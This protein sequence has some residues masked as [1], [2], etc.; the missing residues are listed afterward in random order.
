MAEAVGLTIGVVSLGLQLAES[1]Q[2]V[3]RFYNAVKDAPGRLAD[4]VDE[5][6]S[7]SDILAN[8]EKDHG[9]YNTDFGS[10]M[11]HCI[12]MCRKAV[13]RFSKCAD[14]LESR[15]KRQRHR[16][17]IRFVMKAQ[18]V[19]SEIARLENSKMNLALAYMCYREAM[20]ET[21]EARMQSH[22]V[23]IESQLH[24]MVDKNARPLQKPS[25][26]SGSSILTTEIQKTSK[27]TSTAGN[28]EFRLRTPSWLSHTVWEVYSRR[29]TVGWTVSLRAYSI[30]PHDAAIFKA[31]EHG[32][33][34]RMRELFDGGF[35]SPFDENEF[36]KGIF[37]V[38]TSMD[39][40]NIP[41]LSLLVDRT[42][43]C[44]NGCRSV[45]PEVP[46]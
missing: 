8:M 11:Q 9:S 41:E 17:S 21:R 3:K 30:V 14:G 28:T 25:E 33:I 34:K 19:E 42:M 5:L 40:G 4:I 32:D 13:D 46:L 2:K 20:S 1:I 36:G 10:K 38:S 23:K 29:A 6:E 16:G 26:S 24:H 44:P 37:E 7:F 18:N 45:S 22:L 35:A 15:M 43:V 27:H 39:N 31:C 12:A